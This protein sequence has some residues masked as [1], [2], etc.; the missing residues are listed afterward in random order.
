[1]A[2]KSSGK[3]FPFINPFINDQPRKRARFP[4]P[5][6]IRYVFKN[7]DCGWLGLALFYVISCSQSRNYIVVEI[8]TRDG[9]LKKVMRNDIPDEIGQA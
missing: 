4:V 8:A 6:G 1:M 5:V 3:W 2:Y 7:S 9:L